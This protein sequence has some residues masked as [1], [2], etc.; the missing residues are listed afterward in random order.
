MKHFYEKGYVPNNSTKA[1]KKTAIDLHN[2]G[3]IYRYLTERVG[4]QEEYCR[5]ASMILWKHIN[6][7]PGAYFVSG[8]SGC[9]K[10]FVW[11]TLK[12]IYP[13]IVIQDASSISANGWTGSNKVTSF[14]S[15][16]EEGVSNYIVIF[17]ECDKLFHPRYDKHGSNVSADISSEFLK[18]IDGLTINTTDKGFYDTSKMTFVFCG[19]FAARA[20]AISKEESSSGFGFGQK[21]EKCK[22]F[23]RDL[24]IQDLIDAG[25]IR[26]LASRAERV[27]H[28][29]PLSEADYMHLLKDHTGS[30]LKRIA[31]KNN[32]KLTLSDSKLDEVARKAFSSGLGVRNAGMQIQRMIDDYIFES[33]EKNGTK[34]TEIS[35]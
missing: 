23:E 3:D 9:G 26:E 18:L 20:E 31:E 10:T 1:T 8:P 32:I 12:K 5:D 6:G 29:R 27:C 4:Y 19:S 28:V 14:I 11:E 13:N 2:P 30:P 22:A 7:Q 33:F 15:Q 21:T 25:V 24:D 35:L 16:L 34:P 17:D